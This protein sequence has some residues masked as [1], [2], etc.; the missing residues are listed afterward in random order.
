MSAEVQ[1]LADELTAIINY[2]STHG[3]TPPPS[4]IV[5]A[6]VEAEQREAGQ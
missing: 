3:Y 4:E 1:R 6:L 5:P 2:A